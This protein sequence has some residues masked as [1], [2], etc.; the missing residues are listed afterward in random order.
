MNDTSAPID[1]ST[2][3]DLRTV[4]IS[5]RGEQYST[6][7][8][9]S[10]GGCHCSEFSDKVKIGAKSAVSASLRDDTRMLIS[11][12]GTEIYA[13]AIGDPSNQAIVFIHGF[14]WSLMAFDDIFTNPHWTNQFHLVRFLVSSMCSRLN[15]VPIMYHTL[16]VTKVR[17]DVRGHGRSG[18]PDADEAWESKRFAEDFDTVVNAFKLRK[19]FVAGW[20]VYFICWSFDRFF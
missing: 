19:P 8:V 11:A 17:Y 13:N 5:N 12:D 20:Y 7:K 3:S 2:T 4:K 15:E 16:R 6:L 14:V 10:T 18:K 9:N 1:T